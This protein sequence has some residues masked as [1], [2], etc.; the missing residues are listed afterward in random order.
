M[1]GDH[2]LKGRKDLVGIVLQRPVGASGLPGRRAL[3]RTIACQDARLYRKPNL[4]PEVVTIHVAMMQ[5][6]MQ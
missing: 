3:V 2:A 1:P 6:T 5:I 4:Q